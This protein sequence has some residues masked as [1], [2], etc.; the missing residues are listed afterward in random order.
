MSSEERDETQE[1]KRGF[2]SR[3]FR[4]RDGDADSEEDRQALLLEMRERA[5]RAETLVVERTQE[6]D[7]LRSDLDTQR[8]QAEGMTKRLKRLDMEL[9]DKDKRLKEAESSASRETD[10][11]KAIA[12]LN[13]ELAGT[14]S[15]LGRQSKQ[16]LETKQKLD[17]ALADL[18]A[19]TEALESVKKDLASARR[20]AAATKKKLDERESALS[21]A[22]H[23]VQRVSEDL[24]ELKE[25]KNKVAAALEEARA[26]TATLL[27]GASAALERC[28]GIDGMALPVRLAWRDSLAGDADTIEAT[29]TR[30]GR[31][32][33]GTG[34][35]ADFKVDENG[36]GTTISFAL[37]ST[38]LDTGEALPAYLV[39]MAAAMLAQAANYQL[40]AA[41]RPRIADGRVFVDLSSAESAEN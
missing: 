2:W 21:V 17:K 27:R 15:K 23:E 34:L 7:A 40:I 19:A 38:G 9:A 8:Q 18:E 14:K 25:D 22:M 33:E 31:L 6:R 4:G 11:A 20:T 29:A 39:A 24:D 36:K 32:L 10:Q 37:P 5:E 13:G 26:A 30:I 3:M 28:L 1:E 16:T 35:G 41:A 12:R